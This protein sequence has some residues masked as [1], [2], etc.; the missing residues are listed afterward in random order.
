M[1]ATLLPITLGASIN[2][3]LNLMERARCEQWR[4]NS[5]DKG[6]AEMG[7]GMAL[8]LVT[9]SPQTLPLG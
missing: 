9:C 8:V 5:W 2:P 7:G 4:T 3:P 1:D 6:L